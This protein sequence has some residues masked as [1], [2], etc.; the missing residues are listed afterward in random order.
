MR[1]FGLWSSVVVLILVGIFYSWYVFEEY[2]VIESVIIGE[3]AQKVNLDKSVEEESIQ[4]TNKSQIMFFGDIM[5]AR[6]V[7]LHMIQNDMSYPFSGFTLDTDTQFAVANFESAAPD[8]HIFTP[9]NTFRFSTNQNY[10]TALHL[11]G[12]T[13]VSLA[14][15]HSFDYGLAGYNNTVTKLWEVEVEPFGHPTILSTSSVTVLDTT[16]YTVAI[17]AIHTLF[18]Q[19]SNADIKAVFDFATSKSDLQIAFIHWGEEYELVQSAKQR[20]L[21]EVLIASGADVIIGH[22]PHVVQG[23]EIIDDVPVFYSLGNFIFDQYFSPAVQTGLVL[24]FILDEEPRIKLLPVSSLESKAR[25]Y[26]MN[27]S[28]SED[29]LH[30]LGE[31]SSTK[32]KEEILTGTILLSRL[33]ATS[34][35][36]VIMAE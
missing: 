32:I 25:P 16:Q 23:V 28:S 35:E 33:L 27:A 12:F 21:A 6:D 22:H 2:P 8:P 11:A 29:F 17:V 15:N 24:N 31:R 19:P 34:S 26:Y 18:T 20:K 14:N 9:Y 10:L 13:H 4:R 30:S 5:L 1:S 3:V 36:V 7:E